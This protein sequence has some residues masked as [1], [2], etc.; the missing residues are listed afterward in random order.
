MPAR[1]RVQPRSYMQCLSAMNVATLLWVCIRERS[2][3]LQSDVVEE[4]PAVRLRLAHAPGVH[5]YTV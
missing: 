3:Y 5:I 1:S 4:K 2:M